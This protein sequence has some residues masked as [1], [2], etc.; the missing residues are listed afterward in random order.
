MVSS[1]RG[2]VL[3]AVDGEFIRPTFSRALCSALSDDPGVHVLLNGGQSEATADLVPLRADC[4][5]GVRLKVHSLDL[6]RLEL[7]LGACR[8]SVNSDLFVVVGGG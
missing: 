3:F 8:I 5:R 1:A 2:L 6:S 4:K 7:G